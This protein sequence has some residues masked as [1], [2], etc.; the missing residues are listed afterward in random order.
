MLSSITTVSKVGIRTYEKALCIAIREVC[1][2]SK[3][4]FPKMPD[5]IEDCTL[6]I[7][8]TQIPLTPKAY[9]EYI[10]VILY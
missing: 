9:R 7:K 6:Q 5:P 8:S 1:Y 2:E 3:S 4:D 10:K